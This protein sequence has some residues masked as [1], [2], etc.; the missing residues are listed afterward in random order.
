VIE[1]LNHACRR[2]LPRLWWWEEYL[3]E[4]V[5]VVVEHGRAV[6]GALL[7]W[8]DVPAVAWV[9]LASLRDSIDV[10]EWLDVALPP[11][12]KALQRRGSRVL[13]WMDFSDWAA[14]HLRE[15]GFTQLTGI[16]TLAKSDQRLP[17]AYARDACVRPATDDD[18]ASI[19]TVDTAAFTPYW[20]YGPATIRRRMDAS[21]LFLVTEVASEVVG[22]AEGEIRSTAAHLNRVAVHPGHQGRG[23]GTQ[24]TRAALHGFWGQGAYHITLNTQAD[25]QRSRRL[26]RRLGF[27]STGEN[28][29]AWELRLAP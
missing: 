11:V 20:R 14:P 1:T 5:F 26:Y 29:T 4:D 22:Y 16:Q 2:A 10:G 21:S 8:P 28:V 12:I 19:V 27:E 25:N 17:A 18:F 7:A 15:R 9:R 24:L 13:A 23:I 6:V 3:A